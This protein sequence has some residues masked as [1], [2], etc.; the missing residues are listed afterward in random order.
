M[1]KLP[2]FSLV[3]VALLII[4]GSCSSESNPPLDRSAYSV[5]YEVTGTAATISVTATMPDGAT[6]SPASPSIS[7]SLEANGSIDFETPDIVSLL[8]DGTNVAVGNSITATIY[9]YWE[10]LESSNSQTVT[11]TGPGPMDKSVGV[12][13]TALP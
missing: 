8:V 11:N 9:F 3:F 1:K 2:H 5:R 6:F 12:H 7:W 10:D 4:L 13:Y